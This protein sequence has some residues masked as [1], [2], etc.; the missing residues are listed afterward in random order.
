VYV[1]SRRA[2]AGLDV[3]KEA[4]RGAL[5][6]MTQR[7]TYLRSGVFDPQLMIALLGSALDEALADGFTGLRVT[8]DMTWAL[9][10]ETDSDRLIEYEALLNNFFPGSQALAL[11]QYDRRR[12]A[13]EIIRQVLYTHPTA[14]VGQRVCPNFYY[15]GP[16]FVLGRTTESEKVDWMVGQLLR[17]CGA[18][19]ALRLENARVEALFHGAPEAIALVDNRS[20]VLQVNQRFSSL[21]GYTAD[22]AVGSNLDDL[23]APEDFRGEAAA[24]TAEAARGQVVA[25][26]SVRRAKQGH[27]VDVSILGA[28]VKI[29]EEQVAV[30]AF[31]RDVTESRRAEEAL[32]QSE[33]DYRELVEHSTYGIYRSTLDDRFLS[34]NPALVEML[35]YESQTELLSVRPTALYEVSEERARLMQQYKDAERIQGVEVSWKRKDGRL[36]AVRLSGRP[37]HDDTG[38]LKGFDMLAE[39]VTER[40]QLEAQLRQAQK[41]EAIGQLTGGIAHDFN[42][43][44]TIILSNAELVRGSLP[45]DA[46]SAKADLEEIEMSARRGSE[47]IKKLLG[48]SR[49]DNLTLRPL[50]LARAIT[51]ITQ[52]LPRLLPESI[53]VRCQTGET[54][55]VTNADPGALEQILLNLVTNARDAMPDGGILSIE[56]R[57][58]VLDDGYHALHPWVV[59]GEYGAIVVRD[60]GAG[61]DE[62]T[63]KRVFEPFYT[64]KDPEQGT[65][66]GMAMIY[67]LMKQHNG[68]VHV[69]S[70]PG[71][72]TEVKL[73]FPLTG[74]EAAAEVHHRTEQAAM[75]VGTETILVVEDEAAIRRA[76]KR[77]LER[78]G[79]TVLT[80]GDGEEA[81]EIFEAQGSG[82]HLIITDLIMPKLGGRQL[83]DGLRQRGVEAKFLFTSGYSAE[84]VAE[85]ASFVDRSLP[86]LHKPWNLAELTQCVRDILDEEARGRRKGTQAFRVR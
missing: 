73:Y 79:Y 24:L 1:R 64:T 6:L 80:A 65:G 15:E 30:C 74:S 67:G 61:M 28:P 44:L 17:S 10:P 54:I 12:F 50:D 59:P 29:E 62:E 58:A 77:A 81:V 83:Y 60:T 84:E 43:I 35:G 36:V 23:L 5:R 82:I 48:F 2:A 32:R 34:V 75:P 4:K 63:K 20:T 57:R 71:E 41:M 21:F 45:D 86:F 53:E 33:S 40:R 49:R 37:L 69:Y 13:P 70:E 38:K 85:G 3:T 68:F 19:D 55:G 56:C 18:S 46:E 42:N 14:V 47:M 78:Q 27:L 51:G 16:E 31:Y 52:L 66:L 11:C 7:D 9:G 72:G 25:K 8:G 39:D 22:D 26:E 76:T